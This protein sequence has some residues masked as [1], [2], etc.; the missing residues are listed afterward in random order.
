MDKLNYHHL[1]LFW[2]VAHEGNLTRASWNLHLTPQTVSTQ[3]HNLE[4]SI[5]EKLFQR[6][7]RNLVLTDAGR[8]ALRYADDIFTT[9][10]E[11]VETLRG[12]PSGRPLRLVIG[13]AEVLPKLVAHH[14]IEPALQ[15]DE[16]VRIICRE[17]TS[18]KLLADLAVHAVD[19]VLSDSPIPPA[20]SVRAY[21]HLLG[22]CGVAFMARAPLATKLR[23]GFPKSLDAAPALLPSE[24]AVLRRDLDGWFDGLGIQPAVAGEFDDSA[25]LKVFGQAGAGFFAIPSV[26]AAEVGRQYQ[27]ERIGTTEEVTEQFYAISVERRVSNP[28]VAAICDAARSE[29]FVGTSSRDAKRK[30]KTR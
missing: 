5:G 23:K 11:L 2:A 12:Q 9:G 19:M 29:L 10:Q 17:G 25:L 14:L 8:V 15:M 22:K 6:S 13:I 30:K 27:V 18:E 3:I 1:R 16:P 20:V 7:G 21:N 28:A 26:I 4:D 24:S